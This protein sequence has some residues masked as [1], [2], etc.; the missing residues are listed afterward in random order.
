MGVETDGAQSVAVLCSKCFRNQGLRV[1]AAR[2]G[3]ASDEACPNC[4]APDGL[5]LCAQRAQRL[6]HRF[7]VVGSLHKTEYGGAPVI[8]FNSRRETDLDPN[9]FHGDDAM[10]LSR[11]LGIGLFYYGPPLWAVGEIEPLKALADPET[12]FQIIERILAEYPRFTLSPEQTFYRLRKGVAH[13]EV[14]TEYDSPPDAYCGGGRL[15]S[16][17]LPVL[18]GSADLELCIHECRVTVEDQLHVAT[19]NATRP[20]TLLDLTA[21]LQEDVTSFES[22]DMAVHLLFL[23]AS[24]SYPIARAIAAA[25]AQT[26]FDGIL[27]PSYFSLLRTGQPFLETAYGLST[28]IFPGAAEYEALKVVENIGLFGRPIADGRVNVACINRL[29]MRKAAYDLGFGP[30]TT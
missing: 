4:R 17:D 28:R 23:A 30:A 19:L 29:Y 25:A 2:L 9:P 1:D 16:P 21:L 15:D 27:F 14:P 8:Q 10:L 24:H 22:L 6:A 12:R 13:P 7:F 5:K 11:A 20:L 18:Y 26:G 3:W